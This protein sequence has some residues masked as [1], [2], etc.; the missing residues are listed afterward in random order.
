MTVV[1]MQ[2]HSAKYAFEGVL[3]AL[4]KGNETA[5]TEHDLTQLDQAAAAMTAELNNFRQ[6]TTLRLDLLKGAK[7]T[8][9]IHILPQ[10]AQP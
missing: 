2:V 7:E 4:R 10:E 6:V 9:P 5:Q 3:H 8:R 1:E